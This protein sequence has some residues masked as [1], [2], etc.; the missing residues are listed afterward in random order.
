[1]KTAIALLITCFAH[2]LASAD[3][4][5]IS[6]KEPVI[7]VTPSQWKSTM[8]KSPGRAFPFETCRIAAPAGRNAVCLLSIYDKGKEAFTDPKFL[9]ELLRGDSRPY[10]G[11]P[12]DLRKLE[13]KEAKIDGGLAFYA[14]FVD[15]DL[16]GKPVKLG[17]Y[18]TA[19]PVILGLGSKYLIKV[20][21]L[22]DEVDSADYRDLMKIVQSIKIKKEV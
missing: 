21:V 7:V 5:T 22:C 2:T 15:P 12:E 3:E 9:K 16:V 1:M 17:T 6:A 10:V 18:K 14:D 4:L 8:E 20:T 13:F 11:S 19:T